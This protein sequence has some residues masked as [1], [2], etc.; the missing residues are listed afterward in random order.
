M[1]NGVN[2]LKNHDEHIERLARLQESLNDEKL[3]MIDFDQLAQMLKE[4]QVSLSQLNQLNDELT[5]LREDYQARISGMAKAIAVADRKQGAL[6]RTA[7]LV[8]SL[9]KL[10][11]AELVHC[12]HRISARF[13]DMFPASYTRMTMNGTSGRFNKGLEQYK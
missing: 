8:D 4:Q 5:I 2:R 6:S 3:T 12:Y 13:R 9:P 1:T 11:G 7:E 10:S